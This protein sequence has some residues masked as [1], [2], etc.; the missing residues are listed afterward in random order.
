MRMRLLI[1]VRTGY[2]FVFFQSF[3]DLINLIILRSIEEKIND[4]QEMCALAQIVIMQGVVHATRVQ[5][6][7]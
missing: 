3:W 5:R 2:L 6:S 7:L 1:D 4:E